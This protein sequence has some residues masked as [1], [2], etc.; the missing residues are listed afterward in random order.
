VNEPFKKAG[1]SSPSAKAEASA[2]RSVMRPRMIKAER[3]RE[4]ERQ[5]VFGKIRKA[6]NSHLIIKW[7]PPPPL[8]RGEFGEKCY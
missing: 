1:E 6:N 2:L 5:Y 4:R 7:N 8:P 3:E